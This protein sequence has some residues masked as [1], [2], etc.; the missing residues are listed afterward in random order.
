MY[1]I[2]VAND[3]Q[4]QSISLKKPFVWANYQL[5]KLPRISHRTDITRMAHSRAQRVRI[6][7]H[8]ESLK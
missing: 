5:R 6:W 2:K 8:L 7:S 3:A 1:L 4:S